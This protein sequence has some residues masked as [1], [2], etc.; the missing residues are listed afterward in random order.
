MS[1]LVLTP[2]GNVKRAPLPVIDRLLD[3]TA[4]DAFLRCPQLYYLSYVRHY[5]GK[6]KR[7]ALDYG[8]L[9]HSIMEWHYKTDGDEPL[10]YTKVALKWKD[11]IPASDDHR[12]F[13][14]AWDDYKLYRERW[15]YVPSKDEAYKTVGFLSGNPIIEVF[16]NLTWPGC[17][18]PYGG[19][20]DRICENADG[21]ILVDDHKTNSKDGQLGPY[22]FNQFQ[23]D[24]QFLGYTQLA[25]L[26]TGRPVAGVRCN[27]YAV[28]KT[29][30]A[31]ARQIFRF[32]PH[33]MEQ[34]RE[35]YGYV[36]ARLEE[37]Y[38]S[39]VWHRNYRGCTTKYGSC[40]M[41]E[42]CKARPDVRERI[43]EQDFEVR[44]WNP[45]EVAGDD[46]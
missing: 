43:L 8:N 30:T 37:A 45:A 35:D 38:R 26:V 25:S 13:D 18:H 23:L 33:V 39:G 31:F 7:I 17:P 15:G 5:R 2:D 21:E 16:L 29:K 10:V 1:N 44:P 11:A 46:D 3:N 41:V 4:L 27:A 22:Y 12:T 24:N 14:R 40:S 9:W 32:L 34:W 42:V 6:G 19:K 36:I 20:I 28:L